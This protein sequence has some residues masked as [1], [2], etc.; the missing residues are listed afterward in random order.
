MN[1]KV[2]AEIATRTEYTPTEPMKHRSRARVPL[3]VHPI[4]EVTTTGYGVSG[5]TGRSSDSWASTPESGGRPGRSGPG[6]VLPTVASQAGA[7]CG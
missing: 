1:S 6:L 3:G 4:H 5:A 2:G 7:Q